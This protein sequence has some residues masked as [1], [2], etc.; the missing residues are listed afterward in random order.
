MFTEF[1]FFPL[2]LM[3]NFIQNL[4]VLILS[5]FRASSFVFQKEIIIS[6]KLGSLTLRPTWV[7]SSTFFL[8]RKKI[9]VSARDMENVKYKTL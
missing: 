6:M 7:F 8:F 9:L 5:H 2:F 4:H 1:F 3:M